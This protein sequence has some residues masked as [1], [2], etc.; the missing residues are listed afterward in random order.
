MA[1]G[2]MLLEEGF[3]MNLNLSYFTNG[4]WQNAKFASRLLLESCLTIDNSLYRLCKIQNQNPHAN[5]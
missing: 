3:F 2:K 1:N 5:I 4:K